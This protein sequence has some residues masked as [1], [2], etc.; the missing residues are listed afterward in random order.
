[1]K[2]EGQWPPKRRLPRAIAV[3]YTYFSVVE[4]GGE[5]VHYWKARLD[6]ICHAAEINEELLKVERKCLGRHA[7][8]CVIGRAERLNLF[9]NG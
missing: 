8:A 2:N 1:M 4:V 5:A 9:P 7:R 6:A 3:H